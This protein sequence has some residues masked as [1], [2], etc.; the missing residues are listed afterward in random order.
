[1]RSSTIGNLRIETTAGYALY[2]L[3]QIEQLEQNKKNKKISNKSFSSSPQFSEASLAAP[4][5]S[6]FKNH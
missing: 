6:H 4:V 1:M 2:G 5:G 3:E